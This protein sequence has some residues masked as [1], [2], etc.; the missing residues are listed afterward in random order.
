MLEWISATKPFSRSHKLQNSTTPRSYCCSATITT[1]ATTMLATQHNRI[2]HPSSH[3]RPE[4]SSPEGEKKKKKK[5]SSTQHIDLSHNTDLEI[6]IKCSSKQSKAVTR[7]QLFHQFL[8][9]PQQENGQL[10]WIKWNGSKIEPPFWKLFGWKYSA[11]IA[12]EHAAAAAD[13]E[14]YTHRSFENEEILQPTSGPTVV[15]R[16]TN[17]QWSIK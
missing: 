3:S 14:D 5:V 8:P 17:K 10:C 2:S 15:V 13:E 4:T 6:R 9:N 1:T 16:W 12:A 11:I 7:S